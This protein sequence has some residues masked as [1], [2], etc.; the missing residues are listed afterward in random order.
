MGKPLSDKPHVV[1]PSLMRGLS[2]LSAKGE[3]VMGGLGRDAPVA[4]GGGG[5]RTYYHVRHNSIGPYVTSCDRVRSPGFTKA[6]FATDNVTGAVLLR[7]P[8]NPT[9]LG[10]EFLR[11]QSSTYEEYT[12]DWIEVT[13]VGVR[14]STTVGTVF[15]RFD[16][17]PT[18]VPTGVVD[19][20]RSAASHKG[21][22]P[23]RLWQTHTWQMGKPM[24]GRFYVENKG[25][26]AADLR[27]QEQ[28]N[29]ILEVD[30]PIEDPH[31][32]NYDTPLLLGSMWIEYGCQLSK[33]AIQPN[34]YGSIARWT[35]G[36]TPEQ[37]TTTNFAVSGIPTDP[38]QVYYQCFPIKMGGTTALPAPI[39]DERNNQY[40]LLPTAS[41]NHMSIQVP[42]GAHV[43]NARMQFTH[44]SASALTWCFGFWMAKY[45]ND[46]TSAGARA[47]PTAATEASLGYSFRSVS[48]D[49]FAYTWTHEA[50]TTTS[51]MLQ[52]STRFTVNA[53]D[54][55]VGIWVYNSTVENIS[56]KQLEVVIQTTIVDLT[57][58]A[59]VTDTPGADAVAKR[60]AELEETVAE[61]KE[62][63]EEKKEYPL[64]PIHTLEPVPL[65][66]SLP[67][68]S[69][70][71]PPGR[72]DG[73]PCDDD[74][75]SDV[76][77]AT[78]DKMMAAR[79]VRKS[80][81]SESST[82]ALRTAAP[83]EAKALAIEPSRKVP[84]VK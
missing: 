66:R 51:P 28:G 84:S 31:F 19:D 16:K 56:V 39:E 76:T 32:D 29:F 52:F 54:Q 7:I 8:I 63:K 81:Q 38:N 40:A 73:D 12:F 42:R 46:F 6:R 36:F 22:K 82:A 34:F 80:R 14:P 9:I 30:M 10:G 60:L 70:I 49:L 4:Y 27:F 23:C 58:T 24:R 44:A 83:S 61:L 75:D 59:L 77:E 5:K 55:V 1:E 43:V 17:D 37:V 69:A 15:G 62:S 20:I 35:A 3:H 78:I 48:G 11:R 65:R 67:S 79:A 50:G 74:D 64:P 21:G 72:F 41:S 53:D 26:T 57:D 45:N 2:A 68:F 25:S 71:S 33:T 47:L 18:D 13:F